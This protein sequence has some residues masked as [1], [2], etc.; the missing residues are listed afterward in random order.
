MFKINVNENRWLY[1]SGD[2]GEV[3]AISLAQT[4]GA[5]SLITDDIKQGGPYMSL[6]QLDY[7]VKPFNFVDILILR[8]MLGIA[9]IYQTIV[10]FNEV[11]E[12]SDLNWSLKSQVVKFIKR[13]IA[14]PYKSEEKEWFIQWTSENNIN[15][16]VK[17]RELKDVLK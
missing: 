7:D 16:M 15:A 13:F 2:L 10:D 9:D 4:I 1:G 12:K 8:Y 17:F 11:N 6:M 3:Y 14:D 5:Y